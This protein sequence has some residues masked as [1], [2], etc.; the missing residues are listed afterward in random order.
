MSLLTIELCWSYG[1]GL[2]TTTPISNCSRC[3]TLSFSSSLHCNRLGK[4]PFLQGLGRDVVVDVEVHGWLPWSAQEQQC[5]RLS[6]RSSTERAWWYIM[7]PTP[8]TEHKTRHCTSNVT[9]IAGGSTTFVIKAK[10]YIPHGF[11]RISAHYE[12]TASTLQMVPAEYALVWASNQDIAWHAMSQKLRKSYNEVRNSNAESDHVRVTKI[13]ENA[14]KYHALKLHPALAESNLFDL[15]HPDLVAAL[16][17]GSPAALR[18]ILSGTDHKTRC[19]TE[20]S[21]LPCSSGIFTLPVFRDEVSRQL[22]EEIWHAKTSAMSGLLSV[23]NN[24]EETRTERTGNFASL[25]L[26]LVPD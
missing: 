20:I 24:A 2:F 8:R 5:I 13:N 9:H 26:F 11:A 19:N 21:K 25:V 23:P 10:K 15:L 16:E 22:M 12:Q 18:G 7:P 17:D 14:K 6:V 1:E 3:P 4:S